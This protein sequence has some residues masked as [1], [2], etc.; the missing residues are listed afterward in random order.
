[1]FFSSSLLCAAASCNFSSFKTQTKQNIL[2]FH[3]TRTVLF[4][5]INTLPTSFFLIIFFLN[6]SVFF[7]FFVLKIPSSKIVIY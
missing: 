4:F 6:E 1:L 2:E 5:V 7:F 3:K